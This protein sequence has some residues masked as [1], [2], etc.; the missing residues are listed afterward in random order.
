VLAEALEV[1]PGLLDLSPSGSF[2]LE[3]RL[4]RRPAG[5]ALLELGRL[6]EARL[7]AVE[8][9]L[10][11]ASGLRDPLAEAGE[12]GLDQVGAVMLV[13]AMLALPG[14]PNQLRGGEELLDLR[15]HE[16]VEVGGVHLGRRAA[17]GP[18]VVDVVNAA[19][20]VV[21]RVAAV[22]V[23]DHRQPADATADQAAQEV[24][25][26]PLEVAG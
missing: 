19:A 5:E 16:L 6:D 7:I 18:S 13:M 10:D 2:R 15:P 17:F 22:G 23:G 14:L 25:L 9:T 1:V 26:L 4:S 20:T 24:L 8:K 3:G 21:V 11:L 12:L